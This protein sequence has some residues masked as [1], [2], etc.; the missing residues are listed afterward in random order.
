MQREGKQMSHGTSGAVLCGTEQNR[1]E[2]KWYPDFF[3]QTMSDLRSFYISYS[4]FI[5]KILCRISSIQAYLMAYQCHSAAS[6]KYR[7]RSKNK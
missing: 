7:P 6:Q 5:L 2:A 1:T 4:F 3:Y